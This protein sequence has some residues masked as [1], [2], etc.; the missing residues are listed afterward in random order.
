MM[1]SRRDFVQ[2]VDCCLSDTTVDFDVFYTVSDNDSRWFDLTHSREVL[3]YQPED[4]GAE[5]DRESADEWD[6]RLG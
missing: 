1:T 6:Q 2:F 4:N 3:G 5:W